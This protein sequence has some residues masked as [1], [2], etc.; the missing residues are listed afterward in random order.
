MV[1]P[2]M[3]LQLKQG[4]ERLVRSMTARGVIA[5][6]SPR[7]LTRR[8]GREILKALPPGRILKNPTDALKFF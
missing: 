8:Y 6:L 1:L 4:A 2:D 7:V 3:M 5:I